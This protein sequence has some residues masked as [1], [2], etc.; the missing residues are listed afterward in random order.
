MTS[1]RTEYMG[2]PISSPIVVG[3]CSLSRKI[4]NIKL[5]EDSGAGALV[6]HSLF[7]EQVMLEDKKLDEQLTEFDDI[8]Y[9]ALHY[10]PEVKHDSAR[11]HLYWL[12][13]AKK[14]TKLPLIASADQA[15]RTLPPDELLAA[16]SNTAW[17]ISSRVMVTGKLRFSVLR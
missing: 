4:D 8:F 14:A 3:A 7:E 15:R 16:C 9:E 2:I 13:K 1:L 10:Y 11:Q 5:A 12:T 6:V 17:R